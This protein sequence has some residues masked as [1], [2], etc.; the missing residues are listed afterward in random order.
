MTT[1]SADDLARLSN[2]QLLAMRQAAQDTVDALDAYMLT[3]Q[4][5]EE[6][7]AEQRR[8]TKAMEALQANA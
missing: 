4:G 1:I 5:T 6:M 7:E 3:R 8:L 2:E